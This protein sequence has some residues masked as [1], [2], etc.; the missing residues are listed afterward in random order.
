MAQTKTN[1]ETPADRTDNL[2]PL[3]RV[4]IE[5]RGHPKID[6]G[7]RMLQIESALCFALE[8][9]GHKPD[10]GTV[11]VNGER[12][13]FFLYQASQRTRV[14]LK[15]KDWGY[16]AG[17]T[18]WQQVFVPSGRPTLVAE[19]VDRSHGGGERRWTDKGRPLE[20]QIDRIVA[21]FEAIANRIPEERARSE[22]IAR[23][24]EDSMRRAARRLRREREEEARP[25]NLHTLA[26]DWH[27]AQRVRSFLDAVD[28]RAASDPSPDA[29]RKWLEWARAYVNTFDPL[30][31][32][33]LEDLHAQAEAIEWNAEDDGERD[34]YE[35]DWR[36][37]GMLEQYM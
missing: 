12:I 26:D 29:L 30:S 10:H 37:M 27:E 11:L 7:R 33:G 1:Q 25:G 8:A 14:Q 21:R 17:E 28:A 24:L 5:Q 31:D 6:L 22:R 36:A 9:R 19:P 2:H 23:E 4:R 13:N 34:P 15:P 18:T 3:M 20:A 35:E 32:E 16:R